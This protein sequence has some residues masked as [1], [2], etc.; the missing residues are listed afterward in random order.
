MV[1]TVAYFNGEWIPQK[2]AKIDPLDRGFFVGDAVFDIARTF[3]GKS[4]KMKEHVERLYRSLKY[5]RD[6]SGA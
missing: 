2:E 6:R 4:F 5:T 3:N 1:D